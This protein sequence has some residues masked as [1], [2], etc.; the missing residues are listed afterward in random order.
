MLAF[1]MHMFYI[2][3]IYN[4]HPALFGGLYSLGFPEDIQIRQEFL[5][6]NVTSINIIYLRMQWIEAQ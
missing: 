1:E 2:K 4:K 6:Y 3:W 5:K